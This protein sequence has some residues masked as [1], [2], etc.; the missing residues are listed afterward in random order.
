MK[1]ICISL[2]AAILAYLAY[3][4]FVLIVSV[5]IAI[6]YG[7]LQE[8]PQ[9]LEYVGADYIR[10]SV[11]T[12]ASLGLAVFAGYFLASHHRIGNVILP[13]IQ[14]FAAFPVA[15]LLPLALHSDHS[16]PRELLPFFYT[17]VYIFLS[18]F[19]ELLLLRLL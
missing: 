9:L 15:D 18:R 2:V 11:I 14:A 19:P 8:T 13:A 1:Y 5:P 17:E 7:F 12:L 3:S 16:V 4:S 6:W 10:V